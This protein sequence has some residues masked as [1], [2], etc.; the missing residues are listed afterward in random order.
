MNT[1]YLVGDLEL[2]DNLMDVDGCEYVDDCLSAYIIALNVQQFQRLVLMQRSRQRL[3][4]HS[5]KLLV[6][7]R[8]G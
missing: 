8:T 6:H 7:T 5:T 2:C 4:G 1:V 3:H